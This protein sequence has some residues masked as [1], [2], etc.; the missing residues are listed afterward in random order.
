MC[1]LGLDLDFNKPNV[2]GLSGITGDKLYT[3]WLLGNIMHLLL[4]L[5][6]I[7]FL[8]VRMTLQFCLK[9]NGPY[10]LKIL[11]VY[12]DGKNE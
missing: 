9:E 4:I 7:I 2:K 12:P 1:G 5:L 10:L 11:K 8:G 6:I 3:Y